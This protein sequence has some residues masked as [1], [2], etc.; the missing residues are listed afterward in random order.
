MI[1]VDVWTPSLQLI[2]H[3]YVS[4]AVNP[5]AGGPTS[6]SYSDNENKIT[7][8]YH[9]RPCSLFSSIQKNIENIQTFG[10]NTTFVSSNEL[11]KKMYIS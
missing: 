4:P 9:F 10:V 2:V 8:S 6:S 3:W 1:P 5:P 11:K 7:V